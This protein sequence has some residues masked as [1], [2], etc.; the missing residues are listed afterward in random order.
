MQLQKEAYS[1]FSSSLQSKAINEEELNISFVAL[2]PDN[3]HKRSFW[4]NEFYLSVDIQSAKWNAKTF[5]L[6]HDVS[7]DNAIGK[8]EE[9]KLENG[10]FKV[11]VKF[12]QDIPS[13]LEAFIKYKNGLSQSVSVGF[14]E[15]D[16]VELEPK[17]GIP[18]CYK[19]GD[20]FD[21]LFTKAYEGTLY[22]NGY[23][24][25]YNAFVLAN[26]RRIDYPVF[27]G[28]EVLVYPQWSEEQEEVRSEIWE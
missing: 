14:G 2:S 4:G 24:S 9:V 22:Q 19:Q 23:Q 16:L 28:G 1:S 12:S 13:S 15:C 18:H 21:T 10:A 6:D 25:G 11:K 26:I 27:S 7:F 17:D 20:R 8:I 5:Y 3:L